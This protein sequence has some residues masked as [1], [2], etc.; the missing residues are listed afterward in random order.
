MQS[1]SLNRNVERG[2]RPEGIR[3]ARRR[4]GLSEDDDALSALVL[5]ILFLW[6]CWMLAGDGAT[7]VFLSHDEW[8][9]CVTS[10]SCRMIF[11]GV[12]WR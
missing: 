4:T 7:A 6:D 8:A 12:L 2:R 5:A 10:V 11:S 9:R 1:F 3:S